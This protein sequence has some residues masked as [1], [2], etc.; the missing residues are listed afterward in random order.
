VVPFPAVVIDDNG[1]FVW[2]EG[3][4]GQMT[5]ADLERARDRGYFTGDPRGIFLEKPIGGDGLIPG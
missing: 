1:E 5:F 3:A 2:T 4:R